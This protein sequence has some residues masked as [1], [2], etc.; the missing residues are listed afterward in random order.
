MKKSLILLI[1]SLTFFVSC[2]KKTNEVQTQQ[3]SPIESNANSSNNSKPIEKSAKKNSIDPEKLPYLKELE[4]QRNQ[5]ND[6]IKYWSARAI[7]TDS[8]EKI[9]DVDASLDGEWLLFVSESKESSFIYTLD[10]KTCSMPRL[11]YKD[12]KNISW[13]RFNESSEKVMFATIDENNKC[14]LNTIDIKKAVSQIPERLDTSIAG[15]IDSTVIS[16]QHIMAYTHGGEKALNSKG[17]NTIDLKRDQVV[18]KSFANANS[19]C[20]SKNGQSLLFLSGMFG[21]PEIMKWDFNER[22]L[23]RVTTSEADLRDPKFSPDNEWVIYS[24]DENG[25]SNIYITHFAT[26]TK[27]RVTHMHDMEFFKPVWCDDGKI[28]TIGV[29]GEMSYLFQFKLEEKMFQ[30][31]VNGEPGPGL[32]QLQSPIQKAE[33]D[34]SSEK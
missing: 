18:F 11:I 24:S 25:K 28:Y 32:T 5:L 34:I 27:K 33:A 21:H 19:P 2:N 3:T 12:K 29:K 4:A 14:H 7:I 26:Q 13:A 17:D 8:K 9:L 15:N 1:S 6:K 20:W 31:P 16:A 10:T 30:V 23:Q 22:G